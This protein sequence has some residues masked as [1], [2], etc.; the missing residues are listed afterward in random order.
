MAATVPTPRYD[1]A[2]I[3]TVRDK[4]ANFE[5]TEWVGTEM[6]GEW[7]EAFVDRL[8]ECL[9]KVKRLAV[10]DSVRDIAGTVLTADT[11]FRL[12][13]RLAGNV[14][15]LQEGISAPPW[16]VQTELEWVPVQVFDWR[17]DKSSRG[18]NGGTFAMRVLAGTACPLRLTTFWPTGFCKFI[19]RRAGYTS[20]RS[21]M[22]FCHI[23]E[24]VNL[25]LWVQLDPTKSQ[26]GSPGFWEVSCSA[27]LRGWNRA[28]IDKRFRKDGFRCPYNYDWQC[29]KCPVGY[30]ECP[31]ATHR[32]TR[33]G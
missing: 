13:W 16:H 21:G 33:R 17:A 15:R 12:T 3:V 18:K 20:R 5:L 10:W 24:L 25:R 1:I 8:C 26:P 30:L 6:V 31:A 19:A 11:L 4:L 28:I 27:G 9:P 29:F 22:P 23:S 7:F 32:E 14:V 2:R